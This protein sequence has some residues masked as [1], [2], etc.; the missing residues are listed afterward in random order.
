MRLLA[1]ASDL[2]ES[3]GYAENAAT[4]RHTPTLHTAISRLR[5]AIGEGE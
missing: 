4:A 2:A 3:L 1:Q 5:L